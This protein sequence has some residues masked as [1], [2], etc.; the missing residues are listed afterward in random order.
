MRAA[1]RRISHANTLKGRQI[2]VPRKTIFVSVQSLDSFCLWLVKS[3]AFTSVISARA[4]IA[5]M[6]LRN[7]S[8][9]L[10]LAGHLP[11]SPLTTWAY[12]VLESGNSIQNLSAQEI[13]DRLGIYDFSLGDSLILFEYVLPKGVTPRFPTFCDAY[14]SE[15]WTTNFRPALTGATYGFTVPINDKYRPVPKVVHRPVLIRD[16]LSVHVVQ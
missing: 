5:M 3:G 9:L 6:P 14:A 4:W 2:Q 10:R 7:P 13:R 12:P 16:V 1:I 15:F 11:M 8:N